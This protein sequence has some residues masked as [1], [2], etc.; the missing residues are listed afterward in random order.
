M[1]IIGLQCGHD[2]ALT[3]VDGTSRT[4]IVGAEGGQFRRILE[5]FE[6]RSGL[7]IVLN[8]SFN[9]PGEP[10]V[11]T[12]AQ[13]IRFLVDRKPDVL[14][15]ES[16]RITR[17]TDGTREDNYSVAGGS[18]ET[19]PSC[20]CPFPGRVSFRSCVSE[21]DAGRWTVA[22][23]ELHAE[24]LKRPLKLLDRRG[25]RTA[26][27]VLELDDGPLAETRFPGQLFLGDAQQ[28]ARRSALCRVQ[29]CHSTHVIPT[30]ATAPA[31]GERPTGPP[32][33]CGAAAEI[34]SWQG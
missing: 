21:P 9:G 1:L 25:Q 32:S 28:P 27:A 26:G 3:H 20:A 11:D 24:A 29:D 6:A 17:N 22:T 2:A 31:P 19:S 5:A 12:P 15:L 4:Q 33:R 30:V 18:A 23:D 13:A 7:P 14:Y 10:M 8:T 34:R 16:I